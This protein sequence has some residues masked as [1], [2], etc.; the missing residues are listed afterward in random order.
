MHE[1]S[2]FFDGSS[3]YGAIGMANLSREL[4]PV[5]NNTP[6]TT[7]YHVLL[8]AP[9]FAESPDVPFSMSMTDLL[10]AKL[11]ALMWRR[12]NGNIYL[13]TDERGAE[14]FEKM[15]I[16]DAYNGIMPVLDTRNFGID[17]KRYWAAG[18]LQ[19][20]TKISTPSVILDLDLIVW[21]HIDFS[22]CD[23]AV[24]HNEHT[25]NRFYPGMAHFNT[26]SKYKF[27][28][29]WNSNSEPLNTSILCFNDGSFKS[30]YTK[31]AIRF[32]QHEWDTPDDGVRCMIFAEQHI[33]GMCAKAKNI[34]VKKF[35]NYDNPLEMQN[36][37]THIWSAKGF[38]DSNE[39]V[40]GRY[41]ALCN[42]KIMQSE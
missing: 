26:S 16:S 1:Y 39:A 14:Y 7:A 15:G 8:T 13:I 42:A 27:P 21:N 29:E 33:L 32:M 2:D 5:R 38:I 25:N 4:S 3:F 19:A 20:L 22:N 11:S 28:T 12:Y 6:K 37:I 31:E 34:K 40:K 41:I 30:H 10:T 18:K 23:I 36:L 17:N 9:H 35:L 24:A